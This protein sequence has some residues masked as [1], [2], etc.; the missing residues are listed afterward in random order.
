[1][2]VEAVAMSHSIPQE[3]AKREP[4]LFTQVLGTLSMAI[5]TLDPTGFRIYADVWTDI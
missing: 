2:L 5:A 1:M 3:L 4:R